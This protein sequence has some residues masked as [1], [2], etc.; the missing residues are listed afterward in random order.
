MMRSALL[1]ASVLSVTALFVACS[2]SGGGAAPS[3]TD[4]GNQTDGGGGFDAGPPRKID[5]A[6]IQMNDVSILLPLP[7]NAAEGDLF[8]KA[9]DVG[10]G[11][12][13]LTQAVYDGATGEDADA[14]PAPGG[15]VPVPYA[16]L[17]VVGIR[18]DPCFAN[19]GPVT[20]VASCKNQM[21]LVLQPFFNDADGN[22]K[23]VDVGVH[24]F[25]SLGR[26]E[27]VS[28]VNEVKKLRA[29]S[30]SGALDLG[31]LAVHPIVSK[32]GATGP[33]MTGLRKLVLAHA[34]QQNF[35]RF[36]RIQVGNGNRTWI[37]SGFDVAADKTTS[38]IIPKVP[39]DATQVTF[40]QGFADDL[41]GQFN[42]A[43]NSNDDM[44]LLGN[45]NEAQDSAKEAQKAAFDS[46]LRIENPNKHS[47]NT[48]DCASCHLASPGRALTGQTLGL[49]DVGNANAFKITSRWIAPEDLAI[50][51]PQKDALNGVNVHVFSYK[52]GEAMIAPRAVN[53]TAAIVD[54][55][56]GIR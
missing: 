27:L 28:M 38:M 9:S 36:T 12:P 2:G 1:L 8:L 41:E 21:R 50:T 14:G 51:T 54:Y 16:G 10:V 3:G 23:A 40:F 45:V 33:F 7:R 24:A 11:G 32:E 48:I 49:T 39:G 26:D 52:D 42:P 35:F 25:Y 29:A 55:L 22:V 5:P 4:G 18:L 34:G 43:T 47:P 30:G 56:N 19:I 17:R 15:P 31:P 20:D 37:F 6:T 53:E 44:Q 46:A 13:L